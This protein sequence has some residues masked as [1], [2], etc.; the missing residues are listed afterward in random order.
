MTTLDH[1]L[2]VPVL[3]NDANMT[4]LVRETRTN[5]G[6]TTEASK[7]VM[8]SITDDL[9]NEV[10]ITLQTALL[11]VAKGN[12]NHMKMKIA[13]R[14]ILTINIHPKRMENAWTANNAM[15]PTD[16]INT[17]PTST[18]RLSFIRE[19]DHDM[20]DAIIPPSQLACDKTHARPQSERGDPRLTT[21]PLRET[22][23]TIPI[24]A[25]MTRHKRATARVAQHRLWRTA[26]GSTV[27]MPR[28]RDFQATSQ[29]PLSVVGRDTR[30]RRELAPRTGRL[31]REIMR[32]A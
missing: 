13:I 7:I 15:L 30:R 8:T 29:T 11:D 32:N 2:A 6:F 27:P 14:H 28:K 16:T 21:R 25:S 10:A 31:D 9:E 3:M 4:K 24:H 18:V 19:A 26:T 12:T 20:N 22:I 17:L 1:A 23:G 5:L